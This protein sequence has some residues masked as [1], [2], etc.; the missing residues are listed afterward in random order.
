MVP[1]FLVVSALPPHAG[2][3]PRT[4]CQPSPPWLRVLWAAVVPACGPQPVPVTTGKTVT[5]DGAGARAP[6]DAEC[7]ACRESGDAV[8][9]G[10]AVLAALGWG[11]ARKGE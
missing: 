2:R 6:G 10:A 8:C 7:M 3:P 4:A 1:V 5:A 11:G 9:E